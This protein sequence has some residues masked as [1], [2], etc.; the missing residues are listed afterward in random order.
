M[1][2]LL[3]ERF[4]QV[5]ISPISSVTHLCKNQIESMLHASD[6]ASSTKFRP[7]TYQVHQFN[8]KSKHPRHNVGRGHLSWSRSR[9]TNAH[10]TFQNNLSDS[11]GTCTSVVLLCQHQSSLNSLGPGRGCLFSD[12]PPRRKMPVNPLKNHQLPVSS[13]S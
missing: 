11:F 8:T 6:M 4:P 7:W 9:R 1:W 2:I 12:D 5:S 13:P 3:G 10:L